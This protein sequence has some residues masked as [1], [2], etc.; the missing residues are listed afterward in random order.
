MSL[1]IL[2]CCC[3]CCCRLLASSQSSSTPSVYRTVCPPVYKRDS[4]DGRRCCYAIRAR[5]DRLPRSTPACS[6]LTQPAGTTLP[7]PHSLTHETHAHTHTHTLQAH[8][9]AAISSQQLVEASCRR[10]L[11]DVVVICAPLR[12]AQIGDVTATHQQQ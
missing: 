9:H 11:C 8:D 4:V 10:L 3:C 6:S 1:H 5:D 7:L 12:N 2:K